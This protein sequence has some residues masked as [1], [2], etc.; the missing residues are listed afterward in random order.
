MSGEFLIDDYEHV[1]KDCFYI[2]TRI[3]GPGAPPYL[4]DEFITGCSCKGC[5]INCCCSVSNG[6]TYCYETGLKR[7]EVS[8]LTDG[9]P[10][11][12]CHNACSCLQKVKN[13][14]H[15]DPARQALLTSC[16]NRYVQFGP[17]PGL[18]AS[19]TVG[20]GWGLF[21]SKPILSR[22]FICE[23]AGEVVS[24]EEANKRIK[25]NNEQ[26]LMN[27]VFVL[28]EHF[29]E[30]KAVTCVDP[31][32][33]GNIG[34]YINHS[35]S[36]NAFVVPVRISSPVPHLCIFALKDVSAG[37]EITFDYGGG[38]GLG[39]ENGKAVT[40]CLCGAANCRKWL[41]GVPSAP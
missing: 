35:C 14:F 10:V 28:S 31:A 34:R 37:E 38:G 30:R 6:K 39:A 36:P 13:I 2:S 7:L 5:F 11:N 19:M 24:Q 32:M 8:V 26:G 20:K 15:E 29:G 22:E 16:L 17:V 18:V 40:P 33:F 23:Y 1:N 3:A 25:E 21:T 4:E 41:P 12:E 9:G 27:Y